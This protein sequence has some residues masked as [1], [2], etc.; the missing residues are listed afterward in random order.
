MIPGARAVPVAC[1]HSIRIFSAKGWSTV[2]LGGLSLD[3][4]PPRRRE[5]QQV[6]VG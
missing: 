5:Q 4:F 3:F 1:P 2:C 6:L